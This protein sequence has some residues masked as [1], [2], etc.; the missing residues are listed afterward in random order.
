M[1]RAGRA[2]ASGAAGINGIGDSE[3]IRLLAVATRMR[4]AGEQGR[5][6][7]PFAGG[8]DGAWRAHQLRLVA[9]LVHHVDGLV[10]TEQA[11]GEGRVHHLF[12]RLA[13]LPF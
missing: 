2:S 5:E 11:A 7:A 1:K 6:T 12:E 3:R 10:H 9:V 13:A 4:K 8:H